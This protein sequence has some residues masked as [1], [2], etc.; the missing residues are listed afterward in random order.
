MR[1]LNDCRRHSLT[2][3]A[4][5]VI[6][7]LVATAASLGGCASTPCVP[8]EM[9]GTAG[10]RLFV[11]RQLV[12]PRTD[13]PR[14]DGVR[15][16]G[17]EPVPG[18]NAARVRFVAAIEDSRLEPELALEQAKSLRDRG[19]QPL[20]GP[21]SSAEVA[22]LKPFVDENGLLLVSPSST[23]GTL[24]IPGDNVFRFTPADSVEG[25]ESLR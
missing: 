25:V 24:A 19:A 16:R 2:P 23:A 4:L 6:A 17:R 10:R 14:S 9:R 5:P 12:H 18:R 15:R 22:F 1:C 11:D 3:H 8:Q 21:Q 13:Q 20:I 7:A